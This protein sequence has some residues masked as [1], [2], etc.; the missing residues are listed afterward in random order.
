MNKKYI[1]LFIFSI[2]IASMILFVFLQP[3]TKPDKQKLDTFPINKHLR[4]R[5]KLTNT[6]D[7]QLKNVAVKIYSLVPKMPNQVSDEII[8]NK[9][10]S[11]EID[12]LGNRVLEFI[13]P[14]INPYQT[15]FIELK[16]NT[17]MSLTP[18]SNDSLDPGLF[19]SAS[20]GI[21]I[22]DPIIKK[23][24]TKLKQNDSVETL[25]AY[26][27]WIINNLEYQG[28]VKDDLGALYAI[29]NKKGDCTEYAYLMAALAR[30]SG[31]PTRV[32]G[33]YVYPEDAI[34]RAKDYHNW[35]EVFVDNKWHTIDPQK[36]R[37]MEK[38]DEYITFRILN[39][40]TDA[41]NN[42]SQVSVSSEDVKVSL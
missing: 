19:L 17:K 32:L 16:A 7:K 39:H 10:F 6:S 22:N 27:D 8:S 28:Y 15:K 26:Y 5:Y 14:S 18:Q 30:S 11:T 31:I 33:G 36:Q 2:L 24:A 25:K 41:H 21:E 35:V 12:S 23:L 42:S 1:A 40:T 3:N 20:T 29:Q 34:V 9:S 37:F 13:V 4:M 38:Y